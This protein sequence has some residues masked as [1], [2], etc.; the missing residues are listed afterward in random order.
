MLTMDTPLGPF[1]VL[2]DG[3]V[4]LA[5]GFTT[6]EGTLRRNV[7]P[8]L[9]GMYRPDP[10]PIRA[11]VDAYFAGDVAAIDE[12]QVRQIGSPFRSQAWKVLREV[13]DPIT[14]TRFAE[15]SGNPRAIR[16]AASACATNAAALFVPCHRILR[17]DGSLGGYLWGLDVKREL[18][19]HEQK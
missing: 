2:A 15:L 1:S 13:H 6:D 7:H 5:S 3:P 10:D 14:Y 4:V 8:S 11:A 18:L 12:I 17:T 16:A 19:Q 9:H